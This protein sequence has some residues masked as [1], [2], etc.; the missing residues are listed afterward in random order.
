MLMKGG[1]EKIKYFGV[2]RNREKKFMK[3]NKMLKAI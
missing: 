3:F 2:C 1:L